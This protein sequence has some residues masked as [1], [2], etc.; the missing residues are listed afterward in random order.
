MT[1]NAVPTWVL[2]T[3]ADETMARQ[4]PGGAPARLSDEP[5]VEVAVVVVLH[6]NHVIFRPAI[7]RGANGKLQRNGPACALGLA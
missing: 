4:A 7:P 3:I 5:G 1:T 2:R 6:E